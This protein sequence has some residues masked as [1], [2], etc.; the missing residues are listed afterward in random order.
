MFGITKRKDTR[1]TATAPAPETTAAEPPREVPRSVQRL[2]Q[3]VSRLADPDLPD[4]DEDT[5]AA[6]V[7]IRELDVKRPPDR[8]GVIPFDEV[9]NPRFIDPVEERER[10]LRRLV[11]AWREIRRGE[12]R[13]AEFDH[14][15]FARRRS[16]A[17]KAVG[18]AKRALAEAERKL[19]ACD[20]ERAYHGE[21]GNNLQEQK[22]KYLV[23]FATQFRAG[24]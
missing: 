21:V 2:R 5:D 17:E 1:M 7:L 13:Q 16:D 3:I 10:T 23:L 14:A 11:T 18:D 9:E 24:R 4:L 20:S 8:S 12:E 19:W 15:A 22:S 6:L